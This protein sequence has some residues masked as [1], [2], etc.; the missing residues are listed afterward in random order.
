MTLDDMR[1]A[2]WFGLVDPDEIAI[3]AGS[4]AEA[5][6]NAANRARARAVTSSEEAEV[7]YDTVRAAA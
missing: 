6:A 1:K 4:L 5:L 2:I 7:L 3:Q